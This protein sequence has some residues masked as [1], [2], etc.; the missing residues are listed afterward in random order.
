MSITLFRPQALRAQSRIDSLQG[1]M[2]VTTSMTRR[3]LLAVTGLTVAAV[4]WSGFV[5]VP[6]RV[7]GNG[8]FLDS[9]GELLQ[10]VR[11]PMDGIVEAV[12]VHEGDYVSVGQVVARMRLPE[13]LNA[14]SKS[15]RDLASLNRKYR[16]TEALLA[17][18][19]A[20]ETKTRTE[21][22]KALTGRIENLEKRLAWQR[23]LEQAQVKLLELGVTT[24]SR[25]YEVKAATQQAAEQL[26]GARN[27]LY[28]LDAEPQATA[29]RHERERLALGFQIEQLTSEITALKAEIARGTELRS[30]VSGTVAELSAE[31][32]GLV[33]AN[34]PVL[35][36]IPATASGKIEAVTYVSMSDGKLVQVG[37]EVLIRPSSL[38]SREQG[39]VRG[40]VMEVSE[41]PITDRALTRILGN[42]ALVQQASGGGAPFAVR[43]ALHRDPDTP[44][45]YAWTSGEGPDMRLTPGTP[46]SSRI[47]IERE[48]LLSLAVPALRKMLGASE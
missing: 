7:D 46:T 42:A 26:A 34:Q 15:E 25:V 48:T 27:E 35:S 4:V 18:E 10:P 21:R 14:L 28:A 6:V 45:G 30:P 32:N 13:R 17:A 11:T 29:G 5:H 44:S 33:T 31:R 38:P 3:A 22:R 16:E 1:A 24:R 23:D 8:V 39:R 37:D 47:T 9:S 2:H 41:A 12:L 36:V 40:T 43:I 19:Q 20:S